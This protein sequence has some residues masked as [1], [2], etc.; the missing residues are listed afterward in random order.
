MKIFQFAGFDMV[1]KAHDIHCSNT[2]GAMLWK[3]RGKRAE[4]FFKAWNTTVKLTHQVPWSTYIYLV[5][6]YLA[7][8]HITLRNQV[9]GRY[10][11]FV[12]GKGCN[13]YT[14]I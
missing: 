1:M 10:P 13:E 3:L 9:L 5:E 14:R 8:D 11:G 2:Y 6:G 12:Q 4:S 7:V